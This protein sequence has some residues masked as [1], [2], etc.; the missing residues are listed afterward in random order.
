MATCT[1]QLTLLSTQCASVSPT[2]SAS[3]T[4]MGRTLV[5]DTKNVNRNLARSQWRIGERNAAAAARATGVPYS[6][7]AR[8]FARLRAGGDIEDR[9]RSGR[10]RKDTSRFH[11]QLS[12]MWKQHPHESAA[13]LAHRLNDRYEYSVSPST[14]RTALHEIGCNSRFLRE[15]G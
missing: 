10:P 2:G 7:M 9:S 11:R 14:V 5:N 8:Y 6:T 13:Q 1:A 4:V 12:Y 15:R 3:T